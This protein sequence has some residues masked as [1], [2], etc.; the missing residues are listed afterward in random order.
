MCKIRVI[1]DMSGGLFQGAVANFP[2]EVLV[3]DQ[4][5]HENARAKIPGYGDKCWA[6]LSPA[7]VDPPCVAAAMDGLTWRESDQAEED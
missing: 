6:E 3:V 4:F 2:V 7:H 5:D 1:I